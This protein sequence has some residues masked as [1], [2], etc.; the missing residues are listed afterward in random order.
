MVVHF[1]ATGEIASQLQHIR[2][3]H[4]FRLTFLSLLLLIT[5]GC[6]IYAEDDG[7]YEDQYTDYPAASVEIDWQINSSPIMLDAYA[8]CY[9][10]SLSF[11]DIWEFEGIVADGDGLR[12][13]V[14]VWADVYDEYAGGVFIESFPLFESSIPGVWY[15]DWRASSTWLSCFYDGYTVDLVVYDSWDEFDY[16]TVWANTY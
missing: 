13:V 6:I 5:T 8:G 3:N 11:D 7:V 4:M 2:E 1:D 9:W 14:S 10:D 16:L 15:S 12:D